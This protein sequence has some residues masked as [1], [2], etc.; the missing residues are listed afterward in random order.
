MKSC[1]PGKPLKKGL[2]K[3]PGYQ[4]PK[5][6]T[7]SH[8]YPPKE[9]DP[10]SDE[11]AA[12]NSFKSKG[13]KSKKSKMS[14]TIEYK[15]EYNEDPRNEY[16]TEDNKK[17][18][19]VSKNNQSSAMKMNTMTTFSRLDEEKEERDQFDP[20]FEQPLENDNRVP[21][22][23]CGRKFNPDRLGVHEKT[24]KSQKKRAVFNI[25]K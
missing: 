22:S 10:L 19:K 2:E 7:K 16:K 21:C 25:Q 3:K 18:S 24:C 20:M 14:S 13:N 4:P 6:R 9:S 17:K 23:N 15:G 5:L 8:W 1:K 11:N 12:D